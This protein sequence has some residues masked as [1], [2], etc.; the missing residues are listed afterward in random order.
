MAFNLH[1]VTLFLDRQIWLERPVSKDMHI[2]LEPSYSVFKWL[3][4]NINPDSKEIEPIPIM[5]LQ[6]ALPR[7]KNRKTAMP[8]IT[9]CAFRRDCTSYD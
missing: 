3:E 4:M 5:S 1:Y 6:K 9:T 2:V 8:D 7:S